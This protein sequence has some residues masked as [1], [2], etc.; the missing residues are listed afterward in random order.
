V[1]VYQLGV[2]FNMIQSETY[3]DNNSNRR[4]FLN[5]AG[6]NDEDACASYIAG[7]NADGTCSGGHFMQYTYD[8]DCRC[9]DSSYGQG[10]SS[11][12]N[13]YMLSGMSAP[14]NATYSTI[15]EG[16]YCGQNS[17]R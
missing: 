4:D 6:S 8:G 2:G 7:L 13:L 5:A 17:Q 10:S 12:I 11:S 14:V 16:S 9:C 1:N 15:D 3:C